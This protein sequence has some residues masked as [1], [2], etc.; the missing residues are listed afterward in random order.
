VRAGT[1]AMIVTTHGSFPPEIGEAFFVLRDGK[2][3][4][5]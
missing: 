4:P 2:V 1:A 3:L 5:R